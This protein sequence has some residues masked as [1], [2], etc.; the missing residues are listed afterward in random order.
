LWQAFPFWWWSPLPS[1]PDDV[2]VIKIS[3]VLVLFPSKPELLKTAKNNGGYSIPYKAFFTH[4]WM[5]KGRP[6]KSHSTFWQNVLTALL[7]Y[8]H[9]VHNWDCKWKFLF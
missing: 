4:Y 2:P 5:L 8:L 6:S 1:P 3:Y 9:D 7:F